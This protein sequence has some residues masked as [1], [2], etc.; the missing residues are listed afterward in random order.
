MQVYINNT[1]YQSSAYGEMEPLERHMLS[2][3]QSV[4]KGHGKGGCLPVSSVTAVSVADSQMSPMTDT[5]SGMSENIMGLLKSS[6]KH[7][8][9]I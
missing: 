5:L 4:E 7:Q 8:R 6:K 9:K 1:W 3:N 2:V